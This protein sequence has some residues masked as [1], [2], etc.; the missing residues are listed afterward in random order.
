MLDDMDDNALEGATDAQTPDGATG[1]STVDRILEGAAELFSRQGYAGTTTR[2]LSALV[3]IQNASLYHHIRG[4]E[5]LLYQLC[6]TTL[7][8]VA[9]VFTAAVSS[10]GDPLTRLERLVDDYV[11]LA[12]S[13]RERHSTMLIELRALSSARR[14]SVIEHRDHNVSLVRRL[15]SEAQDAGLI[16]QDITSNFLTLALFN[17]LNWCI[18]WYQPEGELEPSEIAQLLWMIFVQGVAA[19][20]VRGRKQR[21]PSAS[22]KPILQS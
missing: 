4:K 11:V 1:R 5:D 9:A 3:G 18:F 21:S 10:P 13:E 8:S 7:D 15:I 2:E 16:R 22:A 19:P 6:V 20:T 17:L 12:L 14:A